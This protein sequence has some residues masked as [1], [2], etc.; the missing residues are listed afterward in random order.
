MKILGIWKKYYYIMIM[1]CPKITAWKYKGIVKKKKEDFYV[2]LYYAIWLSPFHLSESGKCRFH[3]IF[4]E[5]VYFW[6]WLLI[7]CSIVYDNYILIFIQQNI[8]KNNSDYWYCKINIIYNY[9]ANSSFIRL[10]Q[11]NSMFNVR[12]KTTFNIK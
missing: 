5:P 10:T 3:H 12:K 2:L 4:Q 8:L 11:I 1:F 7:D 9:K 6:V